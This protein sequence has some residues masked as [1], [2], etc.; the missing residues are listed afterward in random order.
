MKPIKC[1]ALLTAFLMAIFLQG[2]TVVPKQDEYAAF[3][4]SN[5]RSILVLPP[6]NKTPD[7]AAS[8]SVFAQV[9][10]PL[11]ES[12]YYVMPVGLV[13]DTF[14]EN[15]L[16]EPADIHNTSIQKLHEIFGADAVLYITVNKFGPTYSVL[17]SETV[18][19]L[20]GK[21]VDLKNGETLWEDSE[22]ASSAETN[23]QQQ[24]GGLAGALISALVMQ[25]I[26][27]VSDDGHKYAGIAANRLLSAGRFH[28]ILFGPRSPY[29]GKD[30]ERQAM[31]K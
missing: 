19:A 1:I 26:A 16:T 6:L 12:G 29:Y 7:V 23:N 14:K 28:G 8:N 9:T 18:V 4:R 3:K 15:G 17:K 2:C 10:R 24:T 25:V 21:L 13:S 30:N 11:A 20:Q 31:P 27:S 5:P 22:S